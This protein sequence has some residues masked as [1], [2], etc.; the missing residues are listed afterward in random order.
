MYS[1]EIEKALAVKEV[2]QHTADNVLYKIQA[3][4]ETAPYITYQLI[5][6]FAGFL[7]EGGR[8]STNYV[9]QVD[10]NRKDTNFTDTKKAIIKQGLLNGWKKND[11]EFETY[12][13]V[14]QLFFSCLRFTFNLKEE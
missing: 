8:K 11:G 4:N 3:T 13:D 2:L 9:V 5:D 6:S 12:D 10:I 1:K 14:S 7:C